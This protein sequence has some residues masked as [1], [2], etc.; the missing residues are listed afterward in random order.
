MK[1]HEFQAKEVFREYKVPVP[2]G[3]AVADVDAAARTAASLGKYPVVVKAQIHAG[4]RGKGG[5]VKLAQSSEEVKEH[6]GAILGMNLV[7]HQTGPEGKTVKKLLIEE[8]LDIAKELYLSLIVDRETANIMVIASEAGGVE[9]EE[10]AAST[11]EKIIKVQINPLLGIQPYHCRQAAFGLNL[12]KAAIK[13]F[14]SM[15]TQLYKLFVAYDCSLVEINPLVLTSDDNVIA[16]DAK[17]DFDDNARFRHQ[18]V[19]EK[20][21]DLDEEDPLEVEASKYNL[22]Y[23]NMDGNVGNMVNGAGLAMAVMDTIKLAG[24]EPANFLDVGGGA[25]AEMVENGFRI[26]LSDEKVK[27]ILIN[28]FG[29]I[30]RCDVLAEGVVAAARNMDVKVPVVV[31]M[32]GTNVEEGRRILKESG[33][34]LF[35]AFD[36]KDAGEQVARIVG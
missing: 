35:T 14:S 10:V 15:L 4:G 6:A 30:L 5:G 33:M 26:I 3:G 21:R 9:I 34:K 12:P 17:M 28:I 8:G 18:D 27:G 29:G 31:R 24:A 2:R 32:E 1:I 13:P 20:Y 22:N 7:T 19:V 25:T 16:L 36:M 23:I 11:P